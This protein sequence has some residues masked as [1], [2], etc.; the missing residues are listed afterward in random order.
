MK[1][2]G[3]IGGLSWESSLVY[4]RIVNE[5]VR[6]RLGGTH[7]ARS[8]M[9]TVDFEQI[10]RH[11]HAGE[12]PQAAA[13]LQDAARRLERAGAD[14]LIICSNTMHRVADDIQASVRIPLLHIADPTA[15]RIRAAGMTRVGL[16]GTAF[17]MQQAFY[18]RR[19]QDRHGLDVLVPDAE[20]QQTV[21]RVIYEEL[22][23]GRVEPTSKVQYV[24]IMQALAERGA[25][26]IILGCTEIMLLV[27]ADDSPVPVFDTTT[28][29]AR[30][31]VDWALGDARTTHHPG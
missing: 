10:E 26:G 15:E 29:H 28:L 7:S 3:L 24:R 16:L 12:W 31:A 5:T 19:L 14:C 8:V 17:T 30:A 18:T 13:I 25:E 21:H 20:D 2:I 1:T 6:D 23:Q 27:G 22:I 4:Y 11:Q 9:Y